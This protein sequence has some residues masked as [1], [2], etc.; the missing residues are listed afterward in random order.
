[1]TTAVCAPAERKYRKA[2]GGRLTFRTE[3]TGVAAI[4][5]ELTIE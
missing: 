3:K 2:E 4:T 1:M 5:S